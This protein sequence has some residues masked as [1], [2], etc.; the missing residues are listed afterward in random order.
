MDNRKIQAEIAKNG[1][2]TL[3]QRIHLK[4]NNATD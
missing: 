3:L 4:L 2:R 1:K